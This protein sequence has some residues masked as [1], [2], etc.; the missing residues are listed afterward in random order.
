MSVIL[1][2]SGGFIQRIGN[3]AACLVINGRLEFAQEEERLNRIKNSTGIM[4]TLAIKEA[5]NYVKL[6][7]KDVDYVAFNFNY[8]QL[9]KKIKSYFNFNFGYCPEIKLVDHHISHAYS[10]YFPSGFKN[11]NII[12]ADFSGNG[13]STTIS[14]AV[15][16]KIERLEEFR[17]PN[18]LGI[19]YSLITQAL[20][21]EIDYDEYKVM[22]L[23]SYGKPKYNLDKI[24]RIKN[25]KYK[26]NSK[27][28]NK[29]ELNKNKSLNLTRQE[30][31]YSNLFLK[32][33]KIKKRFSKIDKSQKKKN[34]AASAQKK[35]TLA[36]ENLFKLAFKKTK[37]N[38]F[39]LAGGVTLN[40]AMNKNLSNLNIVK[41]LFVQPAA[42]DA[43]GSIGAAFFVANKLKEKI[44]I[45]NNFYLGNAFSNDEIIKIL[46]N[47]NIYKLVK[48][49]NYNFIAKELAKYKIVALFQGRHEFGPRALGNRSILASPKNKNMKEILNRKIKYR[50]KFRPFG[51]VVLEQDSEKYFH[52]K[53]GVDYSSMTI[54][55]EVKKKARLKI[56]ACVHVDNTARVQV[57]NFD[58]N[59]KLGNILK[60]F[61][62]ISGDPVLINT[63]FN[64]DGQ[65]NVNTPEQAIS[66]FYSSGLDY[67]I[68]EDF[69]LAKT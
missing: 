32:K 4:P 51:P 50:E 38:N 20:G 44:I 60:E 64:L 62:K 43:G 25:H 49:F 59:K 30:P 26:L 16:N 19:F 61:G 36:F 41:N 57:L 31:F 22:G 24:L 65:P 69:I 35:L 37:I 68:L 42:S 46:K 56:P 13:I 67:L 48:K 5:L 23:A 18:S 52:L 6:G 15:L 12:T 2:I 33:L 14:T 17:K 34:L 8:P 10:A 63:S 53:K 27:I 11:A 40:C 58:S 39:C 3:P 29:D 28:I 21:Y 7:I 1:G 9:L 55:C 66:T 45:K 54:N 47:N